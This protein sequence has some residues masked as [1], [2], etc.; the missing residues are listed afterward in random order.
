VNSQQVC[1]E[2]AVSEPFSENTYVLF[3]RGH[4]D[5][6]ILDPGL[7]PDKIDQ[8]VAQHEL[9][10]VAILNTHG[11][12]DHIAGNAHCKQCWPHSELI[13]GEGDAAKLTDAE[14]NLSAPF[15][16]HIV[17]PPADRLVRD[18]DRLELAGLELEVLSAPGHSRGHVMFLCKQISPWIVF[19]GD[20]LFQGSIGRTDFPDGNMSELVV[21]IHQRLFTLPADT[22]VYPGHGPVTT[23]GEE[24]RL[25]P[26][27]GIPAGYRPPQGESSG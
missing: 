8:V 13:I 3:R 11:H 22:Q 10:P 24:I 2:C 12:S 20:V 27:V 16:F 18:G 9:T 14:L 4:S 6:I 25:N 23:V 7:E 15:G 5:S 21:T 26:F 17:S 19:G 1:V